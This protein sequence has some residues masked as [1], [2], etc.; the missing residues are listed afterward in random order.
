MTLTMTLTVTD[1][2][3]WDPEAV[4]AV[5]DAALRR[6]HGTRTASATITEL[7]RL[8]PFGGDAAEA[9]HAAGARTT[10]MLDDHADACEAVARAAEQSADEIAAIKER[11]KAIR[12]LAREAHLVIDEA[13]GVALPPPTLSAFSP[14]EQQ[15][16]LDDAVRLTERLQQ[17][18]SDADVADEDLAAA[19]R[20]SDGDLPA[21]QVDAQLSHQPPKMAPLLPVLES[22]GTP[23]QVGAW[24]HDLTP[25]QQDRAKQWAPEAIR[26]LDGIPIA[27]RSQ[28]NAAVLQR[29]IDRLDHGW[30][31]A[32]G[33]R[34]DPDKLADLRALQ[35]ALT[36]TPGTSLIL[37]DTTADPR[38]VLA[39][40]GV[41]DVD[42]AER[43]GV[44]V[45]GLNTRVSAS[46]GGMVKQAAAQR[47]KAS[48]LRAAA[49]LRRADA[50]ASIAWLGY[51][52]P[53]S[54]RDVVHDWQARAAAQPLNTFFKG[55]AATGNAAGQHIT[56]FG[57]SYGSL[58]TSL[59]LQGG[60]PVSDVVLYG[61]PGAELTDASQLGVAPGHAYYLIGV[62][63]VVAEVV[64]EFGA[65]GPAPQDV[66]GMTALSSRDGYAFGGR[67]GDGEFHE[68]AYGHSDYARLGSNGELR[69]SGYNMAAVLAGLPQ[70]LIRPG[71][72]APD[73]LPGRVGG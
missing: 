43:V 37:L 12:D 3:H 60:A 23:D 29:E 68:R 71:I 9:A 34:T 22:G 7:M 16:I 56:A 58:T 30:I 51:D 50:V 13:T 35:Q 48:E 38:K 42:N 19:I 63:D 41:G 6:A 5:F 64:S 70:D 28:L 1:I 67:Y 31:G 15:R 49:G 46:V 39:A 11:L 55:L 33:W 62:D 8:V 14:A 72:V 59:A 45:G 44:T 36:T 65:F 54:L 57:H 27:V 18:L 25:A 4:R 20:A 2:E 47:N 69:M 24:W 53:D 26:N 66:P 21:Y 17:L 40:V 73:R 32:Y 52:A 61:S 10:G